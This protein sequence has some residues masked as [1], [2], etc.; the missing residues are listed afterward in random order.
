MTE[1]RVLISV[2]FYS[3]FLMFRKV[4]QSISRSLMSSKNVPEKP[5]RRMSEGSV[6]EKVAKGDKLGAPTHR[7]QVMAEKANVSAEALC[8]IRPNMGKPEVSARLKLLYRRYNRGTSSLDAKMRAES[9][10]MLD[11]IVEVR[12]KFFGEI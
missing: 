8:G 2:S 1:A 10:K 11:A 12:E 6:L 3:F 4:L 9:E 5:V 7:K